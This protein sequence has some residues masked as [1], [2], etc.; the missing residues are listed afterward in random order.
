MT[1]RLAVGSS[2]GLMSLGVLLLLLSGCVVDPDLPPP[3]GAI[4]YGSP[5]LYYGDPF[6]NDWGGGYY[7]GFYGRGYGGT[8]LYGGGGG[9]QRG[10][11]G[12][13]GG[14][15]FHGGGGGHHGH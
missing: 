15:G 4:V 8:R 1:P 2:A 3:R 9:G 12:G 14:G 6:W 13:R 11:F 7:G 5:D 10:G